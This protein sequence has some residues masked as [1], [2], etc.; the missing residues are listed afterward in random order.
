MAG[1]KKPMPQE[2][3]AVAKAVATTR[4]PK[5]TSCDRPEAD[6]RGPVGRRRKDTG[7]TTASR[8]PRARL[9]DRGPQSERARAPQRQRGEQQR[10]EGDQADYRPPVAVQ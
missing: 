5:N 7:S 8:L 1:P 9:R 6:P 3:S 4:Q 10:C 2:K